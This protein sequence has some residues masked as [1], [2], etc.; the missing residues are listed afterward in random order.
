MRKPRLEAAP[1]ARNFILE[2]GGALYVWIDAAGMKHVRPRPPSAAVEFRA[3]R[4]RDIVLY[5]DTSIASPARWK[6]IMRRL[7]TRHIDALYNGE[8]GPGVPGAGSWTD[9]ALHV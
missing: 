7:P 6:L 4:S 1:D 8:E 9:G 3:I 2:H 5:E